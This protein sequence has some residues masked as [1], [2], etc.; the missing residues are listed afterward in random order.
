MTMLRAF[1][2]AVVLLSF[3]L[4]AQAQVPTHHLVRVKIKDARHMIRLLKLDLDLA[5]CHSPETS[6]KEVEVI[7]TDQEIQR[8]Q[9]AGF[10]L[11]VAIKNL[12]DHY[13]RELKK[14]YQPGPLSL[15]PALGKGSMGGHYTL[16]EMEAIL[17]AFAKDYPKLCSKKVSIGKSVEGRNI[18]M[19]KISDNVLI[20]ESE[21]EAFYDALHH[22]REPLSMQTTILFMD[23]LLTG[24]GKD[25]EATFI[26]NE[27][28]LYFVPCVNPDGYEYNR[29]TRPG[30]GGMWR[31]NRRNNGNNV[32]GVDLNRNYTTGWTMPYGGASTSPSSSTYRGTAAFSEPEAAAVE[33]F[34]KGRKF[35][36]VC[37]CHTYTGVL[38]RAWGYQ[39]GD[40]QNVAEYKLLGDLLTA[41]NGIAHGSASQLL[42][43]ASGTALDHHHA[44]RGAISWT[45]EL[46]KSSE[47]GFWPNA[48][49]LVKIARRH[50]PMFRMMALTSGTYLGIQSVTVSEAPGG[51]NNGTVEP[52]ETGKIVVTLRNQ[53]LVAA[54]GA[55][56]AVLVPVTSGISV[57]IGKATLLAPARLGTTSNASQPLT[58][59]V[60]KSFAG[61]LV[62][63]RLLVT[64]SGQ[65]LQETLRLPL[66]PLGLAVTDDME[67]DRG[68]ER[69]SS[70]AT[71]GLWERAAPQATTSGSQ[72]IQPGNQT[73]S[74][75]RLCW[76]TDSRAGSSAGSYD[77][78]GGYTDLVSPVL[79]LAHLQVV[80]VSFQR[81]YAESLSDDAFEVF[82]SSDGGTKWTRILADNK[83]TGQWTRF[84]HQLAIPLTT[85]MRF[86]FRAQD[87]NASL[88]EAAVDDFTIRGVVPNG[89]LT[90]LSSGR[91]GTTLRM[92]VA[93]RP[94]SSVW[95]IVGLKLANVRLPGL[96]GTLRLDPNTA[97]LLNKLPVGSGG[98]LGVD[99]AIPNEQSLV[100][101][102]FHLQLL[103]Q[104]GAVAG[105][106]NLQTVRGR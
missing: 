14:D 76:V 8:I 22:A 32:Y 12:E 65:T 86:R 93:S 1:P 75:G 95:P 74:G 29:S 80:E 37:S 87:L 40:P 104:A 73:T 42:Y 99:L 21:P 11:A 72:T 83:S 77:V 34:A 2:V 56:Q 49:N 63:L 94:A 52:G 103:Y 47:G 25:A 54:T 18:W 35:T 36:Q 20:D 81:W 96:V 41:D 71:T 3:G 27:R 79:D 100:G 48:T 17:D 105:F 82:V 90:L 28:E 89:T 66:A 98:H 78:D 31:K 57:G 59:V 39:Q 9:D 4:A 50:Q 67:Q 16:A 85:K 61:P 64:G 24:Y 19:V 70:T 62:E 7:A 101:I 33:A 58:Y 5:A 13:Q 30:G 46:G 91:R 53:G 97:V 45:P 23:E 60:P 92:G 69:S 6:A 44:A 26:V 38:L 51:N 43:I 106:G 84:V 15:T 88:V 68:F 10:E 55:P 102:D